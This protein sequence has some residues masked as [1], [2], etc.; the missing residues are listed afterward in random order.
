MVL[1]FKQSRQRAE[2]RQA[3]I[4]MKDGL[5][6]AQ[7]LIRVNDNY[8]EEV[9]SPKVGDQSGEVKIRV[10]PNDDDTATI[11]VVAAFPAGSESAVTAER[12]VTIAFP[13]PGGVPDS[14]DPS[15]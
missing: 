2:Q 6:R 4:L 10:S 1:Q 5:A 11:H 14:P 12:S 15:Q 3:T 7:V 13:K 9:W 8:R